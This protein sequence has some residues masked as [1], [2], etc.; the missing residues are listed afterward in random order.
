MRVCAVR[1]VVITVLDSSTSGIAFIGAP[2]S[3]FT[4]DSVPINHTVGS[5][6]AI[7]LQTG[8]ISNITY[9]VVSNNISSCML[10]RRV[11][12]ISCSN[13]IVVV[14]V[15]IIIMVI[16][17]VIVTVTVIIVITVIVTVT[18]PPLPFGR[19]CFV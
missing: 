15:I 7:D 8:S 5:V 6:I 19:I 11:D 14:V 13:V 9:A 17:I 1:Q 18:S 3:F 16:I 12:R 4:V 10:R 2:Y